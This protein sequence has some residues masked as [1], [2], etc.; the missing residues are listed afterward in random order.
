[1]SFLVS[2]LVLT[3]GILSLFVIANLDVGII[4]HTAH[5]RKLYFLFVFLLD[6]I[7]PES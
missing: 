3:V 2:F 5:S 7:V 4:Y 1:M 6:S